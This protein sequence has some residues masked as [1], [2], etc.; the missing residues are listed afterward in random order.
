MKV[1]TRACARL[2]APAQML[3]P[4]L[5]TEPTTSEVEYSLTI[6]TSRDVASA[7][8]THDHHFLRGKRKFSGSVEKMK[9]DFET[10]FYKRES[11]SP[12]LGGYTNAR[13]KADYDEGDMWAEN[14]NLRDALKKLEQSA[15]KLSRNETVIL[16][17]LEDSKQDRYTLEGKLSEVCDECNTAIK[18]YNEALKQLRLTTVE[19]DAMTLKWK[20]SEQ[21]ADCVAET[22]IKT[23]TNNESKA[24]IADNQY[25]SQEIENK[26]RVEKPSLSLRELRLKNI[27]LLTI[28]KSQETSIQQLED[29]IRAL[30]EK[31]SCVEDR[32]YIGAK[33]F[34][35]EELASHDIEAATKDEES[36][37]NQ[38]MAFEELKQSVIPEPTLI[39][40]KMRRGFGAAATRREFWK[41]VLRHWVKTSKKTVFWSGFFLVGFY[42]LLHRSTTTGDDARV[43][44]WWYLKEKYPVKNKIL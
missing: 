18:N 3:I 24:N 32:I 27:E 21:Q 12:T 30:K 33:V 23:V 40:L 17:Q 38:N 16:R 22:E 1:L 37:T 7:Y 6:E 10:S 14:E 13:E 26:Q 29:T 31:E 39:D 4:S 36:K 9:T 5:I 41:V 43:N 2:E 8:T 44:A 25:L 15:K 11:D 20:L 42:V 34:L 35:S 19:L 28:V